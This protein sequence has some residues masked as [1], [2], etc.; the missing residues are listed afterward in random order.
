MESKQS[1]DFTIIQKW[2][3]QLHSLERK[4]LF[5]IALYIITS[6]SL[7]VGLLVLQINSVMSISWIFYVFV[8][9][10]ASGSLII[11]SKIFYLFYLID[12]NKLLIYLFI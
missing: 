5:L 8:L 1:I 2:Y 3:L 12:S 10:F 7:S 6:I 4:I 11:V 9:T